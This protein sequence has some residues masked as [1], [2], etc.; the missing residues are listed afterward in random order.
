MQRKRENRYILLSGMK[1]I[2]VYLGKYRLLGYRQQTGNLHPD[3]WYKY[4]IRFRRQAFHHTLQ[5][6]HLIVQHHLR[7]L[8]LGLRPFVQ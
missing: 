7:N 8:H 5:N 3:V 4:H 6:K 2:P 1:A